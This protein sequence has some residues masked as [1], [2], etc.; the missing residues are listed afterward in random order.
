MN[1]LGKE[2]RKAGIREAGALLVIFGTG[3]ALS[4]FNLIAV[5]TERGVGAQQ[6]AGFQ[7]PLIA[8]VLIQLFLGMTS[9]VMGLIAMFAAPTDNHR[10]H[11]LSKIL[12]AVVNLGPFTIILS[13][14][15]LVQGSNTSNHDNADD[16]IQFIPKIMNA[17]H[18]DIRFV[19]AM[20]VFSLISVCSTLIGGLTVA[21][22]G[23]CA[24]VGRQPH[25]KD[26]RYYRVRYGYYNLLV[27][28][29]GGSQ[30]AL[31]IFLWIK[32]G[33]GPFDEAVHIA[34]YTVYFPVLTTFVGLIQ[35]TVGLY[36][37]LRAV[38][39]LPMSGSCYLYA[40]LSSWIISTILQFLVQPSYAPSLQFD[41]EGATYSAV[42]LGFF[43]MPAWLDYVCRHTPPKI[44]PEY[45]GLP[46]GTP[47]KQDLVVKWLGIQAQDDAAEQSEKA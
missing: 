3:A 37:W 40:T 32:F 19:V 5:I 9:M 46:P 8:A 18:G 33:S 43:L 41:A 14:I 29:G 15:R 47:A 16:R 45:F 42:Y 21:A 6:V 26:R 7:L 23:L 22:L 34:V 44:A 25:G 13:I 27:I 39:W 11:L 12:V 38:A 28:M 4:S 24:F 30:L 35:T 36:G 2:R 1:A 31:G 17:S 10:F 20:G